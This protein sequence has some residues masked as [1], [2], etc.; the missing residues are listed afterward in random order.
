MA[1][2]G[3]TPGAGNGLSGTNKLVRPCGYDLLEPST[4]SSPEHH[5]APD[6]SA[7]VRTKLLF[8][9]RIVSLV[10]TCA[11][12]YAKRGFFWEGV[13]GRG[14][15]CHLLV[16][17]MS[18]QNAKKKRCPIMHEIWHGKDRQQN[19]CMAGALRM[20]G[21]EIKRP[22]SVTL[23]ERGTGHSDAT[24]YGGVENGATE[25]GIFFDA[26]SLHFS[27]ETRQGMRTCA[28]TVV[29]A[30]LSLSRVPPGN[31][32]F[33]GPQPCRKEARRA[34]Y[35]GDALTLVHFARGRSHH[36]QQPVVPTLQSH[37]V[38]RETG[39]RRFL[40]FRQETLFARALGERGA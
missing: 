1:T 32:H 30:V 15:T 26:V 27:S 12:N 4:L 31:P 9:K 36:F 40:V 3:P 33:A 11:L 16:G 28:Q 25:P 6:F 39:V 22:S 7:H 18:P 37:V 2:A 8:P 21:R 20:P 17:Q 5:T 34:S 10:R 35:S 38:R 13:N 29:S 19:P 23:R 14:S 24:R